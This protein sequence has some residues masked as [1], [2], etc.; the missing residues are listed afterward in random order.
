MAIQVDGLE[1]ILQKLQ[2][3]A[4]AEFALE[5]VKEATG[6]VE[7]EAKKRAPKGDVANSIKSKV[8]G[9]EGTVYTNLYYAPYIEYGTGKFAEGEGGGRKEIPWVYVEEN[10]GETPRKKTIHTEQ[11]AKEA[12]AYLESIGLT[13]HITSGQKAQPFMRPAI[14]ENAN[15]ILNIFRKGL[16]DN[17]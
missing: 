16:K 15:E 4:D 13:P 10:R 9:L 14:D 7:G 1:D 12:A 5:A 2:T 17:G 8:D 6:F 11:S 3:L